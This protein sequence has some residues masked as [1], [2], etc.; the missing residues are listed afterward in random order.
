MQSIDLK[1]VAI[2]P[3]AF[4]KE[5]TSTSFFALNILHWLTYKI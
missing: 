2:T 4:L 5:V 3:Y 1:V